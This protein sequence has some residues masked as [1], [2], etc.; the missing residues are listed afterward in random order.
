MKYLTAVR[1]G[2]F[3]LF[4]LICT[5][6]YAQ[7]ST[8]TYQGRLTDANMAPNATY[9]MQF[10]LYDAVT[11]GTQIGSTVENTAVAVNNGV[12]TV[13][14]DYGS[15]A[16]TGAE[17]YLEI[18][19]RRNSSESYVILVPRQRVTSSPHAL[20]ARSSETSTT[21]DNFTG[22]LSGDVEGT[23]SAT[24]V[25][26]VDGVSAEKI[27]NAGRAVVTATSANTSN[28]LVK[29]NAAGSF[30]GNVITAESFAGTGSGIT[31]LNGSNITSGAIS[32]DRLDLLG[33]AFTGK[34][35]NTQANANYGAMHGISS[36]SAS[37]ANVEFLTPNR[38]CRA[39]NLA[40]RHV[41]LPTSFSYAVKVLADG[42][43]IIECTVFADTCNSGTSSGAVP[44]ASR[45]SIGS[46]GAGDFIFGWECR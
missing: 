15:T 6:V 23:Q 33:T 3:T 28:T 25:A 36:A 12:F 44:A 20:R 40:V 37:R 30:S 27:G 13:Q 11:A 9:Q 4:V 21:A 34:I 22:G 43:T 39:Q 8:F 41:G 1:L 17:R 18:S 46:T 31:S 35:V 29:R 5:S 14:L 32:A 45:V 26:R 16:F 24:V 10:A 38:P 42:N 2:T 7:T 19:V